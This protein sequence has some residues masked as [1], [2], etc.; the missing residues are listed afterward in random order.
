MSQT[1]NTD[2][3]ITLHFGGDPQSANYIL[4]TDGWNYVVRSVLV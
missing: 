1:K 4:L 2:G 3:S